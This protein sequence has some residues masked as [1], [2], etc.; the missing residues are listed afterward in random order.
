[1]IESGISEIGTLPEASNVAT[2][3]ATPASLVEAVP[4]P[5]TWVLAISIGWSNTLVKRPCWSTV[6]VMVLAA[7][8]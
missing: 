6:W 7:V 8:P 3:R 1:M 4:S 5:V 2:P